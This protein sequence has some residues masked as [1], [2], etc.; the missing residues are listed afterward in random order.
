[1]TVWTEPRLPLRGSRACMVGGWW[2][3]HAATRSPRTSTR[4]SAFPLHGHQAI[5]PRAPGL[6][7][8]A[9]GS[10]TGDGHALRHIHALSPGC[11]ICDGVALH[12]SALRDYCEYALRRLLQAPV[13]FFPPVV[14]WR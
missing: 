2:G 13:G 3:F 9:V 8:W 10:H 4:P 1:M 12:A 6:A 5:L 11:M 14:R 7:Q